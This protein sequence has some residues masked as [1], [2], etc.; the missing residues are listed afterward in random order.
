MNT[1]IIWQSR[2]GSRMEHSMGFCCTLSYARDWWRRNILECQ[3][4]LS[5]DE[6][7]ASRLKLLEVQNVCPVSAGRAWM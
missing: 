4:I 3:G 5:T 1:K 6:S 7:R 2:D